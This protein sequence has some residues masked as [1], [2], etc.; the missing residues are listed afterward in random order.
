MPGNGARTQGDQVDDIA[1][2]ERHGINGGSFQPVAYRGIITLHWRNLRRDRDAVALTAD[3]ENQVQPRLLVY[4]QGHVA[5]LQGSEARFFCCDRVLAWQQLIQTVSALRSA[6]RD[7]RKA[8]SVV[9][10]GHRDSGSERA[11]FITY[12]AQQCGRCNLSVDHRAEP[13]HE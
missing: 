4:L 1:L 12:L 6:Y 2:R 13:E 7:A 8:R 9:T 11:R 5:R 10:S 3:F